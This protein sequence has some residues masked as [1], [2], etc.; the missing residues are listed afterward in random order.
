MHGRKNI[1]K[2]VIQV[3][4]ILHETDRTNKATDVGGRRG[5]SD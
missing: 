1:K 3:F 2:R 5:D 4:R